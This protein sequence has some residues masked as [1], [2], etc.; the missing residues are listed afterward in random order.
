VKKSQKKY[1]S[2]IMHLM[3]VCA[4]LT[5]GVLVFAVNAQVPEEVDPIGETYMPVVIKE[6]FQ[7]IMTRESE[8]KQKFM[9]RQT[10]LLNRRYD[11]SDRPSDV[12][13]SGEKKYIQ[14]GVR[15]K[16]PDGV[17]W[18]QLA[19]MSPSEIKE[20]DLFPEGFLPLKISPNSN[21]A[22]LILTVIM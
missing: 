1:R 15:V 8:E 16:L 11:L 4:A 21:N 9:D 5:I 14:E 10:E 20:K 3:V 7:T 2:N 19:E 13:M 18:E 17:S 22:P 6:D 12:M